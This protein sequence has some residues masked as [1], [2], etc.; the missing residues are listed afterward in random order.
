MRY[1]GMDFNL[2]R[3]ETQE[4]PHLQSLHYLVQPDVLIYP[5]FVLLEDISPGEPAELFN[6]IDSI[7]E[8]ALKGESLGVGYRRLG[9]NQRWGIAGELPI[10]WAYEQVFN[11]GTTEGV[12]FSP[13]MMISLS[14]GRRIPRCDPYK[15]DVFALGLML[16]EIVFDDPL[17]KIYDY[18]NFEIRLNPLLE[19]LQLIRE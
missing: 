14:Q 6:I 5:D 11:G 9:F 8:M 2:A 4:Q 10:N 1:N 12:F 15:A 13:Q 7:C 17:G 19:K 18:E 16:V 3:S